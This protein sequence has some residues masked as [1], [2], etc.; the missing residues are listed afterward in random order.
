MKKFLVIGLGRFGLTLARELTA[1]GAEVLAI[2][3]N[4]ELI[5]EVGGEMALAVCADATDGRTLAAQPVQEMDCAVVATGESFEQ[6]ILITANLLE[7]GVPRV[8][9][10][11]MTTIQKDVLERIGAHEVIMPEDE[12]G[13]RLA[14]ALALRGVV[15]FVE[16]PE[17]Y[18]LKQVH[19]PATL[20]GRTL[21]EIAM[22]QKEKVL[23]IRVRREEI[24]VGPGGHKTVVEKLIAIPDGGLVLQEGD[25]LS[26][27]GSEEALDRFGGGA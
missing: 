23:V 4:L 13:R 9:S 21:A 3:R 14:R 5:N 20:T 11:A 7:L 16:L 2:D 27:I 22:R 8:I 17:G 12:I 25:L 26:V 24:H 10:R 6:T 18:S 15:D 1:L 19:V